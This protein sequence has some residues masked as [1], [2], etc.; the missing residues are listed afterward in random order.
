MKDRVKHV[1]LWLGNVLNNPRAFGLEERPPQPL[2]D[3]LSRMHRELMEELREE[4]AEEDF[5]PAELSQDADRHD[6]A[7]ATS[8][9]F[10]LH[11]E[12]QALGIVCAE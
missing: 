12:D 7:A 1:Y 9:S 6:F 5:L 8:T 3:V 11:E 10:T 4:A 2:L